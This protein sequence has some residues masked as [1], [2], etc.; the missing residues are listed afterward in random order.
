MKLRL[1]A[2]RLTS[3]VLH[4]WARVVKEDLSEILSLD[5]SLCRNLLDAVNR[6]QHSTVHNL[7][8]VEEGGRATL[9]SDV[10]GTVEGLDF[11]S[12][13]GSEQERIIIELSIALCR[14]IG[15]HQATVLVLD[16]CL[17]RLDKHWFERTSV[18][19]ADACNTFQTLAVVPR[20]EFDTAKLR[21]LGWEIIRTR[22]RQPS[23][24][25]DQSVPWPDPDGL[26][27]A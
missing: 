10:E 13:S 18:R 3:S 20:H 2:L 26:S 6:D 9:L 11:E 12:L 27:A 8:V 7:R 15:E 16:P 22:G 14:A 19:L 24:S 23:V 17:A 25:L 21:W 1:L 5:P 4:H